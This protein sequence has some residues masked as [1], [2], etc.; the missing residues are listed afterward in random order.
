M[1]FDFDKKHVHDSV[2]RIKVEALIFEVSSKFMVNKNLSLQSPQ[3]ELIRQLN[4][5]PA[6]QPYVLLCKI[7]MSL[8][9]INK[10]VEV[11][12]YKVKCNGQY[13]IIV[14][15]KFSQSTSDYLDQIT[16][17]YTFSDRDGFIVYD[18]VPLFD[19]RPSQPQIDLFRLKTFSSVSPFFIIFLRIYSFDIKRRCCV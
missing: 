1:I 18:D 9:Q 19:V 8:C 11:D 2:S 16:K 14:P 7:Y 15:E 3:F 17:R 4:A 12:Y 6:Y 5:D 10:S 13:Q